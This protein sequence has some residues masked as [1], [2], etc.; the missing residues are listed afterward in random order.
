MTDV[1]TALKDEGRGGGQ[2][3]HC[4]GKHGP[5]TSGM[6]ASAGERARNADSQAAPR[7]LRQEPAPQQGP[8]LVR[9]PELSLDSLPL[10]P[11]SVPL[12]SGH[13]RKCV[14]TP[15]LC[16]L[17]TSHLGKAPPVEAQ[18][19]VYR[20]T[21]GLLGWRGSVFNLQTIMCHCRGVCLHSGKLG[22]SV[23]GG[24]THTCSLPWKHK[25]QSPLWG[26]AVGG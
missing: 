7:P 10:G 3:S 1:V 24:E 14:Q 23:Q 26:I 22:A 2:G 13:G 12:S 17:A 8:A 20:C 5:G 16:P 4:A 11:M 6:D 18:T 21:L 15:V 19:R 25:Q 9:G